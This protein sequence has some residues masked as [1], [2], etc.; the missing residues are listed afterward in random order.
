V[1]EA[2]HFEEPGDFDLMAQEEP[3]GSDEGRRFGCIGGVIVA[4]TAFWMPFHI[5]QA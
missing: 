3:C 4:S 2:G 5:V 1:S